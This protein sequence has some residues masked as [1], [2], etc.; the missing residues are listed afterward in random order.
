MSWILHYLVLILCHV[1]LVSTLDCFDVYHNNNLIPVS[2]DLYVE[3]IRRTGIGV[4]ERS[5][6]R[7]HFADKLTHA[8]G[9]LT[10]IPTN[11]CHFGDIVSLVLDRNNIGYLGKLSC[12]VR[13]KI[14]TLKGN[15]ITTVRNDSFIGLN[16]TILDLSENN[17]NIMEPNIFLSDSFRFLFANLSGNNLSVVD[18]TNF[19][20]DYP[21]CQIDYS[22]NLI[23]E[24]TNQRKLVLEE[25]VY[26]EGGYVNLK[27]NKFNKFI[28]FEKIGVFDIRKI[29]LLY[30]FSFD[31]RGSR[32]TCDATMV[33][34]LELAEFV[35]RK[36][37]RDF[38]D[39]RCWDPMSLRGHSI[40]QLILDN[41]LDLFVTE[42]TRHDNCPYRCKCTDQRSK[43]KI[44]VNCTN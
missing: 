11:V 36:I 43:R 41:K 32:L 42:L 29:G 9:F 10:E 34:F 6:E 27:F 12:L 20:V 26:G 24:I 14:L 30:G 3:Y 2:N 28:D 8:D 16:L 44:I 17:I 37:W 23:Y 1:S 13:L 18:A 33:P 38:Y 19:I 25:R 35:I 22:N 21:Y 4:I 39:V 31:V 40:P 15:V 5:N 7:N